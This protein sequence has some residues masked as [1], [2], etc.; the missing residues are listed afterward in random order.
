MSEPDVERELRELLRSR[1]ATVAPPVETYHGVR[2]RHRRSRRRAVA[3]SAVA[4]AVAVTG[5]AAGVAVL[6]PAPGSA[7]RPAASTTGGAGPST[8]AVP[9]RV[10]GVTRGSLAR[11]RRLLTDAVRLALATKLIGQDA[12]DPASVRVPFAEERDGAAVVLV[13]GR[14]LHE[15]YAAVWLGRPAGQTALTADYATFSS[16]LNAPGNGLG[17]LEPM[18]VLT[19]VTVGDR[20]FGVLLAPPGS[21]ATINRGRILAADCRLGGD[22]SA[23]PLP[24]DDG[25]ALFDVAPGT[26]PSVVVTDRGGQQLLAQRVDPVPGTGGS[27]GATDSDEAAGQV[28]R[29]VRGNADPTE[30]S[31]VASLIDTAPVAGAG[32]PAR[33]LGVWAGP[34]PGGHGIA[35]LFGAQ[36][37]SGATA[38]QGFYS[39][40][41][42][43]GYTGWTT[44]CL[45]AGQLDHHVIA[46]QLDELGRPVIVVAPAA[47]VRAEAVRSDRTVVPVP[48]VE[49][50]AVLVDPGGQVVRVRAYDGGGHVIADDAPD[51]ALVTVH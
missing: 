41:N 11:D 34:L 22:G 2:L 51:S 21:R 29:T 50:G 44:G 27:G 6:R 45:P 26:N 24:L 9:P 30:L 32:R 39:A 28:T 46:T 17:Y 40:S 16:G 8:A 1:A 47:A 10:I 37:A 25:T 19:S 36:Y 15:D 35:I 43:Q 33:H 7:Q 3:G 23:V 12:V 48:L 18:Q 20:H 49:G 31:D 13:V 5:T 38:L 14:G 42:G 4:A